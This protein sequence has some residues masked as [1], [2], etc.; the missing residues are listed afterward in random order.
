MTD[1]SIPQEAFVAVASILVGLTALTVIYVNVSLS[2][3]NTPKA[4]A[5]L[6]ANTVAFHIASLSSADAGMINEYLNGTYV[7]RIGK[8]SGLKRILKTRPVNN[9]YVKAI[10]YDKGGNKMAESED[11][12][13]V[14][15]LDILCDRTGP[16]G[17]TSSLTHLKLT[18]SEGQPVVMEGLG[19]VI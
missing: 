19:R 8:Y 10:L 5:S 18:K 14:G 15:N 7:I 2:M 6:T 16:C 17:E 13:F 1:I 3:S 4:Q 9:Y 12:S 11:V